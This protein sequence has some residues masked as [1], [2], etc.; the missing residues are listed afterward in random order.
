MSAN[1]PSDPRDAE[2]EGT[3]QLAISDRRV[4]YFG[5]PKH[6]VVDLLIDSRWFFLIVGNN[7]GDQAR[8]GISTDRDQALIM[9]DNVDTLVKMLR[10]RLDVEE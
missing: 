6:E 8:Y 10:A 4:A 1:D 5:V 3:D 2:E 9:L 7:G